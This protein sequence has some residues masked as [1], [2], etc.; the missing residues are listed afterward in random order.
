MSVDLDMPTEGHAPTD[1]ASPLDEGEMRAR[2]FLRELGSAV[3][4]FSGGVDSSVL[5]ALALEE[6]GAEGVLAATAVSETY[7][8]EELEEARSLAGHLGARHELL[9]TEELAIPGFAENPPDRCFHCKWELCRRL[10]EL[11]EENGLSAVVDGVNADDGSDFRPGIRAADALHVRHPLA[12]AGLGKAAVRALAKRLGL[13]NSDRPAMACL[14]SRFPYGEK[15]TPEKLA[16]VAAAEVFLKELGFGELRVRH[17]GS[18]ARVE[19]PVQE[20]GRLFDPDIRCRV[21]SGL[22][23][24]GFVY[25]SADLEGFR[26]GSMN[27]VFTSGREKP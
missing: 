1:S 9:V 15:I 25:V 4:A 23:N 3:V 11:A 16:R 18:I 8:R 27:E 12:E 10:V 22:K 6:L 24:L 13:P 20:L 7:S 14:A 2:A 19:V 17:H 26:S 5:L 21:V